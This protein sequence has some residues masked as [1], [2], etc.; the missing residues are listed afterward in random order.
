MAR[1][2]G[3]FLGDADASPETEAEREG[4][5]SRLRDSLGKT[6]RA[7]TEQLAAAAFDPADDEAWERLEEALIA[8]DVGVPTTAELVRRLEARPE[9]GELGEAIAREATELLG[10][11]P[12]LQLDGPPSVILVVGVNGTGKT[13]TIGKLAS[14]L[15]EHGHSVILAAADTFR[16][17]AEEQLEIWAQRAG[18]DFVGSERGG[19]PA[20]VAYDAIEAATARGRDVVIVDTAGRLHTQTNLMEEL[21]KV[22]RVIERRLEG[23]PH[24]TLLVIDATTGQNGLQ[25]ARLFGEAVDVSGVALTKLDG[26]AKGGVALAIA[27]ELGLKV[28][29]V[30]VGEGIDDLRP[31]DPQDFARAL[32][33]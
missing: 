3:E 16:A 14:R 4:F 23:A 21:R 13:T 11:P 25:Q 7:M 24:E 28:K 12:R 29:L 20:A 22:R 2:W 27:H 9:L 8:A 17:A 31:F 33:A 32:L 26:S 15:A 5:F 10:D 19:D 6:R 30:G 1:S 18:A